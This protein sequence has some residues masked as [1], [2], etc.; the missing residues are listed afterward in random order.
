M[1]F[2]MALPGPGYRPAGPVDHQPGAAVADAC[3][4]AYDFTPKIPERKILKSNGLF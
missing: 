1:L 2:Q 4:A 3:A